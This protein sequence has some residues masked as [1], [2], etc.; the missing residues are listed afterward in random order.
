MTLFITGGHLTPALAVVDEL[1]KKHGYRLDVS[2]SVEFK[3]STG[4]EKMRD[5]MRRLS[6]NEIT[7]IN[8]H[9]VVET[10]DYIKQ[11]ITNANGVSEL[12][13]PKADVVILILDDESSIAV[14]PSGTEPKCKFYFGVKGSSAEAI[15]DV[16]N[17]LFAK[18]KEK[19][20]ID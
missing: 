11:I 19:L 17:I 20:A 14:R 13:L 4:M 2:F 9:H 3:G 16:P 12:N 8:H 6:A 5:I 1:Q 15:K 7:E 10:R 18:L